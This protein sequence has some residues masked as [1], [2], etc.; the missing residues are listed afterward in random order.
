MVAGLI[1]AGVGRSG[2]ST[3]AALAELAG[4]RPPHGADMMS[5]NE[6]NPDGH[7]ESTSLVGFND[8]LLAAAGQNWWTPC[9][10]QHNTSENLASISSCTKRAG[11]IFRHAFGEGGGWLWKDPR[12]TV[13]LPFWDRVLGIQP[14][15]IPYR[16]PLEVAA[17]IARRDRLS[18]D[19]CLAIWERHSRHMLTTA[20]GH[21]VLFA[22]YALLTE[23]SNIWFGKLVDFC[24]RSGLD[25]AEP[26]SGA[27]TTRVHRIARP[28]VDA[29]L[30]R[31]QSELAEMIAGLDGV[32]SNFQTPPL[33]EETPGTQRL[34]N[35]LPK[36]KSIA[37]FRSQVYVR[38][39]SRDLAQ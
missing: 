7:W 24:A 38:S 22:D 12:L 30:T 10:V 31:N 15:L 6:W 34:I 3:A 25:V 27:T 11:Q 8:R 9:P 33:P 36:P 35:T 14:L 21:P 17:S 32:H 1:I 26:E 29:A 16:D 19:V 28:S 2:T 39:H 23:Q 20:T 18:I 4:L 37:R 5:G 13:L